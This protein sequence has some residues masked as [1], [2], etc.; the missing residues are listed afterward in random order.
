M[1]IKKKKKIIVV[2]SFIIVLIALLISL[3]FYGLS[4]VSKDSKLVNFKIS[5]GTSK[6]EIVD[7]LKDAG[8][9][10]SKFATYIY[11]ALNRNLNLQ[12]GEY[13][14]NKNMSTQE[15]L[16]KIN[17]GKII[18]E[19]N[20]YTITFVEGKRLVYYAQIIA[21]NTNTSLDEVLAILSD[22]EYL[23]YLIDKYWFLSTE[24][25]NEDIY[26]PLEGYL[27]ASTYE[28]YVDSSVKQIV[29]RMLDGTADVLQNFKDEIESGKYTVHQLLTLASI[30]ELEGSNSDDRA[31][32]AGVFYNRLNAGWSLG[33]DATTYYA[34]GIDFS[35][36]DLYL[37]EINDI[38]AYNTR[39]Q[40]MAGKLPVGP[41]CSPSKDSIQAVIEPEEHDYYYFVADK[42]GK[43][44]FTKTD[45]QHNAL[46]DKL[47]SEGLWYEYN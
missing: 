4:A 36:R 20:T 18:E 5:E 45:A 28:F 1:K 42:N 19:D 47:I 9:I 24:I 22:E 6:L 2:I 12:A 10:K 26:Y 13:A 23:N 37:S 43:T 31:G 11:V 27:F 30:V 34:A 7:D 8:L 46:V 15:I 38:N 44:Y 32:V 25:L 21:D 14:L 29:E 17:D 16:K 39:P 35:E 40:A 41:I 3:Y 33:S